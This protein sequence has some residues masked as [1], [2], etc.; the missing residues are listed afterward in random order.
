MRTVAGG[1]LDQIDQFDAQFFNISPQEA[2]WVDPQQRLLLEATWEALEYALARLWMSFGVR[3]NAMVGHSIG[4]VVA[5]CVAG[6]FSLP[7]A[8]TLVATRGR[9]MQSVSAPGGMLAVP[10]PAA[11]VA[12]L[13]EGYPDLAL[14]APTSTP[15]GRAAGSRCPTTPSTAGRTG[16]R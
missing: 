16:C 14:A 8:V 9:L 5:A 6:V 2:Q 1:F 4:E 3:P 15:A 12:P 10:A 7:E 11:D 13:L